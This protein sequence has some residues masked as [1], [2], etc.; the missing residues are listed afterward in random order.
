M[1]YSEQLKNPKWQKRRL[2]IMER[3]KWTCQVCSDTESTL[4]VHHKSYQ[5]E[6][7]KFVNVWD[8]HDNDLITLCDDCHKAEEEC[9]SVHKRDIYFQLVGIAEDAMALDGLVCFFDTIRCEQRRRVTDED[10]INI[11]RLY[12]GVVKL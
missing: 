2:E 8:Y 11:S 6:N 9:L 12:R 5:Q 3:D 7:G 10:M 1:S 4:T